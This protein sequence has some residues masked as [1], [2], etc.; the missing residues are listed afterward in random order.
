MD[1]QD[2]KDISLTRAALAVLGVL[3]VSF[4][5]GVVPTAHYRP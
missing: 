4:P 5:T 2:A 3:A 1:R